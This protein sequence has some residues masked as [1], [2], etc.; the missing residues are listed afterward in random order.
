MSKKPKPEPA[1]PR[2]PNER[3]RP[4]GEPR[5]ENHVHKLTQIEIE[6]AKTTVMDLLGSKD[7][8]EERLKTIKADFKAKLDEIEEKIYRGRREAM[9]GKRDMEIVV[10]EYLTA[11]NQVI[12][13]Q[14]DTGLQLGTRTARASEL[15]EQLFPPAEDGAPPGDDETGFGGAS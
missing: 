10:Q 4:I 1:A 9:S 5:T 11:A 8:L 3:I 14:V 2:D 13:I 7:D 6:D 12:R 15:Q